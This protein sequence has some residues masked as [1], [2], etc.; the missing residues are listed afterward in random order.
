MITL[1][2]AAGEV[3]ITFTR[4]N[5]E[6]TQALAADREVLV[7]AGAGAGKTT[8]LA[9]RFVHLHQGLLAAGRPPDPAAVLVLTFTE[10]A[11]Q[12]MRERCYAMVGLVAERLRAEA[13]VLRAAG[14]PDA[15]LTRLRAGWEA[16]R[17]RFGA[18]TISTFHG[19]CSRVLREFPAETGTAPGFTVLDENEARRLATK[20]AEAAVDAALARGDVDARQ[21]LR[22]WGSRRRVVD[23]LEALVRARGEV[24]PALR[25]HARGVPSAADLA[26]GAPVPPEAVRLFLD[27]EWRP[28][29]RALLDLPVRT[30]WTEALE[31]VA[32]R[33]PAEAEGLELLGALGPALVPFLSSRKLRRLAHHTV[34]GKKADRRGWTAAHDARVADLQARV[35]GWTPW[36]ELAPELPGPADGAMLEVL[37]AAGRLAADAEDRYQQALRVRGAVDYADLQLRVRD[38]ILG[39]P[40]NPLLDALRA[41]HRYVMVDEFQDTDA[42][43]WAI[44]EALTRIPGA[45]ADRL[46]FVGD[47]KQAIYGFRGGDVQVFAAASRSVGRSPERPGL[48]VSLTRNHRSRPELIA[49]FNDLFSH[50]LGPDRPERPAWEAAFGPLDPARR[51]TGGAVVVARHQADR[52][53]EL[54]ARWI[55]RFV[56]ERLLPAD[57]PYAHLRL[58]DRAAHPTPPIAL[59][60]RRRTNLRVYEGALRAAGV[61]FVV[62]AG[63]G[64]WSR[65]EV[66]DVVNLLDALV[67]R[68]PVARVGVLRS[69]LFDLEDQ[70]L[71][72]L[73]AAGL[74]DRFGDRVAEGLLPERLRPAAERWRRL[75]ELAGHAPL[76]EVVEAALVESHQGL[77]QAVLTPGGR[78]LANLRQLQA[79]L[80]AQAAAGTPT[81]EVVARMVAAVDDDAKAAE[82]AP[83]AGAARVVLSTAHGAKGLEYPVVILPELAGDRPPPPERKVRRVRV[84]DRWELACKAP[85]ASEAVDG[86][87]VPGTWNRLARLA[88]AQDEAES[89]RLFYVACTRARDLLVLVQQEVKPDGTAASWSRWLQEWLPQGEAAPGWLQVEAIPEDLAPAPP[90]TTEGRAPPPV[91]SPRIAPVVTART[92]QVSPSSLARAAV[93]FDGWYA[94]A[95]LGLAPLPSLESPA[96]DRAQRVAAVRGTVLHGLLEDDVLDDPGR[97]RARWRAAIRAEGLGDA[98]ETGWAEL[99]R[100]VEGLRR[101][102]LVEALFRRHHY[103]EV[104]FHYPAGPLVLAGRI[105]LLCRD[106]EDGAW[107]VVDYKSARRGGDADAWRLQLLCYSVAAGSVLATAGESVRRGA[108]LHTAHARL[109][110]LPDWTEEDRAGLRARLE[111]LGA[112]VAALRAG[113]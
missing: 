66:L 107:M 59:L 23:E 99:E 69:P 11:A 75:A 41:R 2:V 112:R 100:Q 92:V 40:P 63:A 8:T 95:V 18:A 104:G 52:G 38:A 42:L 55:A 86:E 51:E 1:E 87:A 105:D 7:D 109:E 102:G 60:F 113:S 22:A 64:F 101:S 21:L 103:R 81:A 72:D 80:D 57:G 110:R 43:Q 34:L 16:L 30:K 10:R 83:A 93:D 45:P 74:L 37:G 29:A 13:Q 76:A 82:A 85:D 9:A 15:A 5:E 6:Q 53:Q 31:Q 89:R 96:R 65:Q 54:E 84:G 94:E 33:V 90:A 98:E 32:N 108:V 73:A 62:L 39:P 68:D 70:D 106:P 4:L 58:A 111:A 24:G 56:A 12:E 44:V 19:F 79:W 91:V 48:A 36:V 46:F 3:R 71:V 47:K 49:A 67:R 26:A 25:G 50:V 14:V 28:V 97:A 20:A 88:R 78:A 61:P 17:D 27:E 77:H 35:D